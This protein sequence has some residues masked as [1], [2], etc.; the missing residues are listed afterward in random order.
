[1]RLDKPLGLLC[2]GSNS[3]QIRFTFAHTH[4]PLSSQ[5]HHLLRH[6]RSTSTIF[7]VVWLYCAAALEEIRKRKRKLNVFKT[8]YFKKIDQGWADKETETGLSISHDMKAWRLRWAGH[9]ARS[10]PSGSFYVTMNASIKG[11]RPRGSPKSRW[12]D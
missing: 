2:I 6:P 12:I 3:D 1:M 10:N 5:C 9:V 8:V 11:K 4:L 7:Q